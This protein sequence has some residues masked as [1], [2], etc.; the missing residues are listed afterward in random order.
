M[1]ALLVALSLTI[2]VAVAL[3]CSEQAPSALQQ[4]EAEKKKQQ[5]HGRRSVA[6]ERTA[7]A[8]RERT[9]CPPRLPLSLLPC[10]C[11]S[12]TQR[13]SQVPV[14]LWDAFT[15]RHLWALAANGISARAAVQ[16]AHVR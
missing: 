16:P 8:G 5:G 2:A 13:L 7:R 11:S 9:G 3:L 4:H 12:Q 6:G 15:G 14:F 10:P 1:R